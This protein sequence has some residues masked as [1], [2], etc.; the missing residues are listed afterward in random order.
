MET[1]ER[2]TKGTRGTRTVIFRASTDLQKEIVDFCQT[3]EISLAKLI[4][5]AIDKIYENY[6]EILGEEDEGRA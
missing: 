3:N 5:M 4:Q 6:K 1:E 2:K